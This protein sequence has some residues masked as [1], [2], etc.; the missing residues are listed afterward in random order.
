MKKDVS[1]RGEKEIKGGDFS[2]SFMRSFL[3]EK[4]PPTHPRF[5]WME[6]LKN[7]VLIF[8]DGTSLSLSLDATETW[9]STSF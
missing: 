1:K 8:F 9:L 4:T 7:F 5:F 3:Q 2:K 6:I